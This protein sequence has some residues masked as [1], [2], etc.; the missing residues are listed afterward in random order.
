MDEMKEEK[1]EYEERR[2]RR[3]RRIGEY[4]KWKVK[5]KQG[6]IQISNVNKLEEAVGESS[7]SLLGK[8]V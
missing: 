2:T 3:K 4:R 1:K 8:T 6:K 5:S 7:F